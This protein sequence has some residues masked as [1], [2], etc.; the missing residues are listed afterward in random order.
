MPFS[1]IFAQGPETDVLYYIAPSISAMFGFTFLHGRM[2]EVLT[3]DIYGA[4]W[5]ILEV[6]FSLTTEMKSYFRQRTTCMI[7]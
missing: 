5:V 7:D 1:E 2:T 4:H 6:L 3:P